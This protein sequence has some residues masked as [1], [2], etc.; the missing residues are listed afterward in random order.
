MI[1]FKNGLV[2]SL[3]ISLWFICVSAYSNGSNGE[4]RKPNI[5]FVLTDDQAYWTLRTSGNDQAYSPNL[6]KLASEG[7]FFENA[8]VTTPVCSPSRATLITGQYASEL[9]IPDFIPQPGHKLY[10]PGRATG[11]DPANIT[12][13][14]VLRDNGYR[15]GLIGKW[16]LGDWTE[17]GM[18]K[19]FHPTNHGYGYFMGL[20]GGGESPVD[21]NLEENGEIHQM[22]GLTVDILT[23][24]ALEFIDDHQNTPFLLSV[25]YRSPHSK[26][27]PVADEDWAPYENME[28]R[29]P[30]PDYPDLDTERVKSRM[31]EYLASASGI[32]R[33]VG[34]LMK[35]LN[36]LGLY[37]NT[38]VIFTSDHGYNM[39]HN[40]IEHKG[41]GYWITKGDHPATENLA[42]N[43]RPNLYDQS[44]HIPVLIR[45][46]GAIQPDLK[47]KKTFSNLDWFPT[48]LEMANIPVPEDK[49]LRGRSIVPVLK[50]ELADDWENDLY[51]EYSMVNYSTAHMRSYR[52]K[53]W[54]LV[55]DF[56]D[57]RRDELYH[58]ETDP[59]EKNNLIKEKRGEI[60]NIIKHLTY[61]ILSKMEE[62]ND[63]LLD[64]ITK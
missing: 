46:P 38:I 49:T 16:H 28:M 52:T 14:E 35:K 8:F 34:K 51:T 2:V 19:K 13:A 10:Q 37:E 17:S 43:S 1:V 39:G 15:T 58:L 7:A 25:H 53:K 42:K 29:V 26:W 56:Q 54:K 60:R 9:G 62:L 47:I 32:D 11:L 21:P 50:G 3:T 40:G 18:D 45:W 6:D 30:H 63:P 27:L 57:P 20:T 48:L 24:R 59:D 4:I 31:K 5:L 61:K 44:L 12:F 41:N 22:K 33:N 23:N 36:E 55:K 64:S